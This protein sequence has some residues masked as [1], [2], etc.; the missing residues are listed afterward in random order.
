MKIQLN[1]DAHIHGT[2]A[3]G[4][5]IGTIVEPALKRFGEYIT[6][7]EV[8]LSDENGEKSGPQDYRCLLEARLKGRQPVTVTEHAAA[9]ERS[10]HGAAHK[11]AHLLDSTL[12]R[13]HEHRERGPDQSSAQTDS[14]PDQ[15]PDQS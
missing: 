3:L 7:L 1:T 12:G 6:R 15:D 13:L 8:H 9:L 5:K 2:E 10:V 11:L 14:G 4:A